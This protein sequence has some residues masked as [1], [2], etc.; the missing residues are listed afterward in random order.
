MDRIEV[1]EIYRSVRGILDEK[2]VKPGSKKEIP[3]PEVS[4][5]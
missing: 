4:T 2:P 3:I 1:E 5:I